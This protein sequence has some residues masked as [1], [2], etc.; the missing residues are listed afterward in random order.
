MQL[1]KFLTYIAAS[2]FEILDFVLEIWASL[3]GAMDSLFYHGCDAK[4][5]K[6]GSK[7]S[8]RLMASISLGL[9]T[10]TFAGCTGISIAGCTGIAAI[11]ITITGTLN[12]CKL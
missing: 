9:A 10:V 11:T 5:A 12:A 4:D 3:R 1:F 7:M 8:R 2:L 6:L